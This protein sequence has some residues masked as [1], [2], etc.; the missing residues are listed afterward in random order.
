MKVQES[1]RLRLQQQVDCF[2]EADAKREL[3]RFMTIGP[4]GDERE[5]TLKFIALVLI[6]AVEERAGIIVMETRRPVT[7]IIDDR[8]VELPAVQEDMM[9]RLR[10]MICR[11]AGVEGSTTLSPIIL[12]IRGNSLEFQVEKRGDVVNIHLPQI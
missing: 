2:L 5:D 1:R 11:I 10:E 8:R 4:P 6:Q 7:L 9:R 3:A 12:D